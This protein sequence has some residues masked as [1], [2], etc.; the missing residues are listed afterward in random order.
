[1]NHVFQ[2]YFGKSI[3]VYIDDFCIYSLGAL[4]LAWVN[5]GLTRLAQL[6]GKLNVTKC[7]F[8]E[9]R[10]ALLG[11]VISREGTEAHPSKVSTL[12]KLPS[13][14]SIK[15]LTSFL[16]KVRYLGRFIHHFSQLALPLQHL[17][18]A[19]TLVWDEVSEES[20]Q[21]VEH[22]P[23]RSPPPLGSII[24]CKSKCGIRCYCSHSTSKGSQ[25]ILDATSLLH[26][27]NHEF[28]KEGI[29]CD[30]GKIH[31]KEYFSNFEWKT[32]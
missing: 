19:Q 27:P 9:K 8:G 29:H 11:H 1:M 28:N 24:F 22:P 10:V 21:E 5:E 12:L 2:P 4:H 14:T 25:D 6:G 15:E 17:T 32:S 31:S 3:R 30:M 23:C 13:P 18:N 7:L 16:Q 20:F 26:Q